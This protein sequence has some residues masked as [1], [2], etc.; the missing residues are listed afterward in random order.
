MLRR[1]VAQQVRHVAD[2][3]DPVGVAY[4]PGTETIRS[5]AGNYFI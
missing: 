5:E 3:G 4:E 1:M 2:G